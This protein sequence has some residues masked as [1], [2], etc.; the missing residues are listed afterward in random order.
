[1]NTQ[2][3]QGSKRSQK[4]LSL[5]AVLC[6]CVICTLLIAGMFATVLPTFQRARETRVK[7][8]LRAACESAMDWAT[9]NLSTGD[10]AGID[11]ATLNQN[12]TTT[13]PS[14]VLGTGGFPITAQVTVANLQPNFSTSPSYNKNAAQSYLYDQLCD[15]DLNSNGGVNNWRIVT[16]VATVGG[17]TS[18]VR[19]VLK[20]IVTSQTK[21]QT[22]TGWP[23]GGM[24]TG[25]SYT[26]NGKGAQWDYYDS[27]TNVNPSTFNTKAGANDADVNIGL[28]GTSGSDDN[29]TFNG[30]GT[31]GGDLNTMP[32]ANVSGGPNVTGTTSTNFTGNTF[33]PVT[34]PTTYTPLAPITGTKTLVA[35][36]YVI[37]GNTTAISGG[38]ITISGATPANPVK[39][40]IETSSNTAISLSGKNGVFN[41]T[42]QPGALQ[43]YVSGNGSVNLGGNGDLRAVVYAP[44][45]VVSLSGNSNFYGAVVAKSA[46]FNGSSGGRHYDQ[47]L[48]SLSTITFNNTVTT[49]AASASRQIVSWQEF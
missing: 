49:S 13:V 41:N 24:S 26:S 19:C 20:P 25:E 17:K 5:P 33:P 35:G 38:P 10:Q 7:T 12:K 30:G 45:S 32:G 28:Q 22:V 47:S 1:M 43:I 16:S 9:A 34:H 36:T 37:T 11:I 8:A 14:G 4:G 44:N 29:A 18:T 46:S 31:V 6:I 15:K 3:T 39:I 2:T 48:A 23:W 40:F 42:G 21:N 27:N